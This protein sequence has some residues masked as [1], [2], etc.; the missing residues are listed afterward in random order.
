MSD[1]A[2]QARPVNRPPEQG[3]ST[4]L[5]ATIR[6]ILNKERE[7]GEDLC[8]CAFCKI[9]IERGQQSLPD[10]T[11]VVCRYCGYSGPMNALACACYDSHC[12]GAGAN[13]NGAGCPHGALVCPVCNDNEGEVDPWEIIRE[14]RNAVG[15]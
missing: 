1:I 14:I 9:A 15:G 2:R 3:T 7:S 10:A 11:P 6:G 13:S 5:A 8:S 12:R 4:V